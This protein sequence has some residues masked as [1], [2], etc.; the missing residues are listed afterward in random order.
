MQGKLVRTYNFSIIVKCV[1]FILREE[2][3][4][5][6]PRFIIYSFK[7]DHGDGRTSYPMCLLFSTPRDCKTELMVMY[8][9]TKLSL[10]KAAE[11]TKVYEIRDLEELTD[12]W[13]HEKLK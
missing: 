6:Q 13:L 9:G 8:A 12:E 5:H 3:P 11:L 4:G 10:V 1:C 2:L 7:L